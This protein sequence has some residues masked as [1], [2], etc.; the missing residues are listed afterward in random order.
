[1]N[2]SATE[3]A[4]LLY[5]GTFGHVVAVD[6]V[7]G[8]TTWQTSLPRT[9]YEVVSIVFEHGQLFCGSGGRVFAL[10]PATGEILWKNDLP[11]LRKN[12]M[13]LTTQNSNSTEQLMSVLAARRSA[14]QDSDDGS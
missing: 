10:D 9:G 8:A 7:T 12:L 13:C 2:S 3:S 5:V 4:R 14:Q 1:M 6:Q 11:G